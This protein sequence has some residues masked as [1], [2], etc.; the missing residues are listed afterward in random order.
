MIFVCVGTQL[1]FHRLIRAMDEWSGKNGVEAFAQIANVGSEG[2]LPK[3][4]AWSRFL[5]P[6]D[7]DERFA[8]ADLVVAHAGMGTII[9]ALMA[10]K[11]IVIMPRKAAYNEHRNDHQVATGKRFEGRPGVHV[12]MDEFELPKI[13]EAA[14]SQPPVVAQRL[15]RYADPALIE[16]IRD[17]IVS[18]KSR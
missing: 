15:G 2:Y 18:N 8:A 10:G 3:N 16:T 1:P 7:W 14:V 9:S 13:V 11:P 12:A 4:M 6:D 5:G 17:F